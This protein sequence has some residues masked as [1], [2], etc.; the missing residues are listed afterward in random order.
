MSLKKKLIIAMVLVFAVAWGVTSLLIWHETSEQLEIMNSIHLNDQEKVKALEYEIKEIFLALIIPIFF[1]LL[2]VVT[3]VTLIINRFLHPFIELANALERKSGLHLSHIEH[4]ASMPKEVRIIIYRLNELFDQITEHIEYE[5]QFSSNVAHEL[6]TPLAGIR[7]TIE[8]MDD[9]P[10]KKILL[11]RV[12]DLLKII[13][14]LLLFA[15]TSHRLRTEDIIPFNIQ[16]SIVE[17]LMDEYQDNFPHPIQW[18]VPPSLMLKAD[19]NLIYILFKNLLDNIRFYAAESK[20]TSISIV[21]DEHH[22]IVEI[23][24]NGKGISPDRL[25]YM[26]ERYKRVDESRN[27][28]G[29]GLS[30]VEAI[31][32]AHGAV[33]SIKNREDGNTGLHIAIRFYK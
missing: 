8:L 16:S 17:P 18:S 12:D 15:R 2:G 24:D 1:V 28:F 6:R 4:K 3:L 11:A 9:I 23:K 29:L 33:L 26:T 22:I 32:R 20:C 13:E 14:R 31:V 7:L 30:I 10:E 25:K 21:E 19:A 27:G 5:K